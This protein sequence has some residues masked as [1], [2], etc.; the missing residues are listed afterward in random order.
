MLLTEL[1]L[2]LTRYLKLY[3][4]CASLILLL[5]SRKVHM[6]YMYKIKRMYGGDVHDVG[7]G[8]EGGY[9]DSSL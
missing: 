9:V 4:Q 5:N 8:L 7:S 2:K 3:G 1:H 6:F